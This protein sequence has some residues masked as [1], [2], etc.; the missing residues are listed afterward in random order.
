LVLAIKIVA[1]QAN[2]T[3]G[4][5]V[6]ETRMRGL[7]ILKQLWP[8]KV[9]P[10]GPPKD[11]LERLNQCCNPLPRC[12]STS[13]AEDC[14]PGTYNTT[15]V[16]K[17]LA[18]AHMMA[19]RP[20]KIWSVAHFVTMNLPDPVPASVAHASQ[21]LAVFLAHNF[22]CDDCRGFFQVGVVE[23]YGLPPITNQADDIAKWW[24]NGHNVAGEHVATTRGGH[25]WIHELGYADVKAYQNPWYMTWEDAQA[26][27]V[28]DVV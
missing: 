12:T 27:W 11:I 5:A 23:E 22:W 28:M 13:T 6:N 21:A 3:L 2:T 1:S 17:K 4:K 20:N 26:M 14:D 18:T 24:W 9:Y 10:A 16:K 7:N 19:N 15:D 25:P 8:Y